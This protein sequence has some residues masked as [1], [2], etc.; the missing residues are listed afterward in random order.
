V[1]TFAP[2]E[3]GVHTLVTGSKHAP[4]LELFPPHTIIFLPVQIAVWPSLFDSG[5][6][7]TGVHV[8]VAGS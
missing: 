3:V 1:A 7:G 4:V 5:A 2:V 8:F 6:G